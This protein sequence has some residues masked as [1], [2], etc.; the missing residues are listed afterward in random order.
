MGF[1]VTKK[2]GNAVVRNRVRRRLKE[3]L[4]AAKPLETRADHDYVVMA[5]REALGEPFSALVDQI[6]GAFAALARKRHMVGE[7][8]RPSGPRRGKG[9]EAPSSGRDQNGGRGQNGG[10]SQD[11]KSEDRRQ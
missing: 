1:T 4:R 2:V 8:R 5:R 6:G 9:R 3:A 11:D 7:G 10:G